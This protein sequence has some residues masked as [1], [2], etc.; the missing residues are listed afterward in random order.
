MKH[1]IIASDSWKG[2]LTSKE[3]AQAVE[4]SLREYDKDVLIDKLYVSDGG[5]GFAE[6]VVESMNGEW[7]TVSCHDALNR[8]IEAQYGI[9]RGGWAV[10]D[11]ASTIGLTMIAEG[12]RDVWKGTS[13][14]VGEMIRSIVESGIRRVIIGLGGSATNDC[15]RD[16][17]EE[18]EGTDG[19]DDCEFIIASDVTNPLCGPNG[20][21]YSFAPQKGAAADLLP[22]LEE[23]NHNYALSLEKKYNTSIID[24]AGSGAAGGIGAALMTM[25]HH[26]FVSGI[27]WMMDLY[28]FDDLLLECNLVITGEGKID[29][30]TMQGKVPYGIAMRAKRHG[31][32]CIALCGK[33]ETDAEKSAD[34]WQKIIEVSP[35][36]LALSEAMKPQTAF[37]NIRI[38]MK[39]YLS[40]L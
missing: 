38:S 4:L 26:K 40:N 22:L 13:R 19:L 2:C 36:H 18:L 3:V 31:V 25:K 6:C 5:E 34:I 28:G 29:S 1:V 37:D 14:G 33:N 16:M 17:M 7:Q 15:G 20:A 35:P 30:Q 32:N 10:M 24:R 21:T 23:R 9:V 8:P 11:V 12:E 39:D 27:D